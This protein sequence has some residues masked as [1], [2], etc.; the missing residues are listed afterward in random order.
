MLSSTSTKKPIWPQ[1]KSNQTPNQN[2]ITISGSQSQPIPIIRKNHND[3]DPELEEYAPS[4]YNRN[5]SDAIALALERASISDKIEDGNVT[6]ASLNFD[7]LIFIFT[8]KTR[9]GKKKKKNKQKIL[10]ATSMTYSGK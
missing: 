8:D 2:L 5:F 9:G 7:A 1:L 3:S 6:R 10:F 4:A